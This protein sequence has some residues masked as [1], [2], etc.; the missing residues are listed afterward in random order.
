MEGK[1]DQELVDRREAEFINFLVDKGIINK[2]RISQV[3][4]DIIYELLARNE[5][6]IVLFGEKEDGKEHQI[7]QDKIDKIKVLLGSGEEQKPEAI[8]KNMEIAKKVLEMLKEKSGFP[9]TGIIVYGSRMDKRK[10][11][12]EASDLDIVV[13]INSRDLLVGTETQLDKWEALIREMRLP[14][15]VN[16]SCAYDRKMLIQSISSP[17]NNLP[18]SRWRWNP[19]ALKFIGTL[20]VDGKELSDDEV[21]KYIRDQ[22]STPEW[23]KA[24]DECILEIEKRIGYLVG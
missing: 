24:K 19:S 11:P 22:L 12:T 14:I 1:F 7:P 18:E 4:K 16:I 21:T 17:G 10:N 9:V 15:Q 20:Y 23:D 8:E 2:T 13:Y 5:E 6:E 3:D